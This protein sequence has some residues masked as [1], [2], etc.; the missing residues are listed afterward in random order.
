MLIAHWQAPA[1]TFLKYEITAVHGKVEILAAQVLDAGAR[2]SAVDFVGARAD[3]RM[4]DGRFV[5]IG[6]VRGRHGGQ[7]KMCVAL[8]P[9]QTCS[10]GWK[11]N[12][13]HTH[14]TQQ[15]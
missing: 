2:R 4:I 8:R 5:Q 6:A 12:D 14:K 11:R 15:R 9:A 3:V 7:R 1:H 13:T 10:A